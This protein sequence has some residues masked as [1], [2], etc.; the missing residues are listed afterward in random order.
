MLSKKQT[1]LMIVRTIMG[2]ISKGKD[3]EKIEIGKFKKG[4]I[5]RKVCM[6]R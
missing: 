5:N 2:M 4:E 3:S 6:R 1:I